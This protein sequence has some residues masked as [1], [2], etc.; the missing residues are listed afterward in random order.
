MITPCRRNI[1][2]TF[3]LAWLV[4][5]PF[6]LT[7]GNITQ[8]YAPIVGFELAA[9]TISGPS[10]FQFENGTTG[11]TI[12]YHASDPNPKNYTVM[13]G[14][15]QLEFGIWEG[16][17]I[18]VYLV[19]LYRDNLIE[20][21]PQV[22]TMVCT[23]FNE[24]GESAS[25]TTTITVI[26]DE[27]API[28]SQPDNI[29][30]ESGSFGHEIRWNITEA[31]PEF[32]NISRIS[33]EPT[34]NSTVLESGDWNGNNITINVDGLN[35]SRWYLY[36]LFVNDT[37]GYNA[38][39]YVNVTVVPDTTFPTVTSPDDVAYEFGATGFEILWHIY[40][41]NPKN[42]SITDVILYNDTTYG[43]VVE[44]HSFL[45]VFETSWSFT[46][47]HGED[48]SVSLDGLFLGNYTITITLFDAYNRM[49][50]DSVNVTV[51][52]DLRAPI[53]TPSGD[54]TYEEGYT[55]YSIN[56]TAEESNPWT[57]NLTLDGAI[58]D[59]GTWTG[60]EY[61]IDVDRFPVG[62][63]IYNMT[64][65]DYFNQSAFSIIQVQVTPDAHIPIV[66]DVT[67]IQTF[68]TINKNN[69]TIHAYVWDLN[70]I[71]S[72]EVCWGVGNPEDTDFEFETVEMVPSEID[73]MF[74]AF[75]GEFSHGT[76]VW[77]KV[78]AQDNAETPLT[79]DT[80]W[81]AEEITGM[82]INRVSAILYAVVVLFGS[83]S[84]LVIFVLYFRTRT[85]VRG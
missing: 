6:A 44:F 83:L 47:P 74:T 38:T 2:I 16:G 52:K 21:L 61:V 79:H 51:Y 29:T 49:T 19:W 23:V 80:G 15:D 72:I 32:Y 4:F 14:D 77:Y 11:L 1:A 36:T 40:D 37:F 84:L 42:Y 55:G 39:S 68:S 67:A 70:N 30:Y 48:I 82:G 12:T 41:S 81:I 28:I 85:K 59:N 5:S 34:S 3:I 60:A 22:L 10:T 58:E 24:A 66:T 56:W 27:F 65:T 13:V 25:A 20:T 7:I 33:N 64:F 46:D 54:I 53:I 35:V 63:Y 8:S 57:F 78:V 43:N 18:I 73:N 45:E 76:V 17:D 75:L 50:T 71:S 69:L 26:R 31:N 62:T 9:P